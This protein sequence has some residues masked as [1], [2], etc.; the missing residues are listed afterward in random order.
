VTKSHDPLPLLIHFYWGLEFL[1]EFDGECRLFSKYRVPARIERLCG[2]QIVCFRTYP[3]SALALAAVVA[4]VFESSPVQAQTSSPPRRSLQMPFSQA[5]AT[6]RVRKLYVAIIGEVAHPGTYHLDPSELNLHSVVQRAGGLTN[7][8]TMSVHVIRQGRLNQQISYSEDAERSAHLL[9]P[10]DVVVV[11]SKQA[12][13]ISGKVTEFIQDT[14]TVR[15]GF[16]VLAP[17]SPVEVALLNVVDYPLVVLLPPDEATAGCLLDRL[18]QSAELIANIRRIVPHSHARIPEAVTPSIVLTSGT[19]VVFDRGAINRERLPTTLPKPIESEIAAGAQS[20]LIGG[21]RGQSPEL[22]NVGKQTIAGNTNPSDE[23]QFSHRR[24]SESTLLPAS[25]WGQP[26]EERRIDL[27]V[28]DSNPPPRVATVPIPFTGVPR[29]TKSS[30][31]HSNTDDA[32]TE[33]IPQPNDSVSDDSVISPT[34]TPSLTL[35]DPVESPT[36]TSAIPLAIVTLVISGLVISGAVFFRRR[37]EQ[38]AKRWYAIPVPSSVTPIVEMPASVSVKHPAAK[39]LLERVIKSELPLA[40]ESVEFPVDIVLQGR[41]APKPI[42]R[43]DGPQDVL[44]QQGPHFS[45]SDDV[46]AEP[47]LQQVIAQ[48]DAP[49]SMPRRPHFMSKE[50][51]HVAAPIGSTRDPLNTSSHQGGGHS[52]AP[53]ASALFDLERGDRS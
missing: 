27:P 38:Q 29:I 22:W 33:Q 14:T 41:I 49:E 36:T 4:V 3:V 19:A 10:G 15:A 8:A 37:L 35:D 17:P 2:R 32:V 12:P 9:S 5:E 21:P 28:P 20:G 1:H 13:D 39:T 42:L 24:A 34:M 50:K 51:Q 48:M 23:S 18:G 7:D 52:N 53:L 43:V 30:T 47:S 45:G 11:D 26:S 44:E 6:S 40:I 25:P 46:V 31:G 16:E